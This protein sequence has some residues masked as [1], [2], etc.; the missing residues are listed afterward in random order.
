MNW[1]EDSSSRCRKCR[2]CSIWYKLYWFNIYNV[3]CH[4]DENIYFESS[5]RLNLIVLILV[6]RKKIQFNSVS[7]SDTRHTNPMAKFCWFMLAIMSNILF[8]SREIRSCWNKKESP[9]C[10]YSEYFNITLQLQILSSAPC[11]H[12]LVSL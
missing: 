3:H 8:H 4:W 9:S 11:L 10:M 12:W 6:E 5:A 2:I 1:T 7:I